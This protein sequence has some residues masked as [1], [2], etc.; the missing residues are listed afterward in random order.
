MFIVYVVYVIALQ[1]LVVTAQDKTTGLESK[2]LTK[3]TEAT[4]VT[5][6]TEATEA[7]KATEV[8]KATEATKAIED[9][10]WRTESLTD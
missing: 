7:T 2:I 9:S 1:N 8:T 10:D 3:A 6:A 5:K 4:E